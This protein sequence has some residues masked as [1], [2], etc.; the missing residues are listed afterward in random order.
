M[1]AHSNKR[2]HKASSKTAT[3]TATAAAT[4]T[5]HTTPTSTSAAANKNKP[6]VKGLTS[7]GV[8]CKEA[9]A[10]AGGVKAKGKGNVS[11]GR[12]GGDGGS[13]DN[14]NGNGLFKTTAAAK[15]S[16]TKQ[17]HLKRHL[18]PYAMQSPL[19]NTTTTTSTTAASKHNASTSGVRIGTASS[20]VSASGDGALGASLGGGSEKRVRFSEKEEVYLINK[21]V[22]SSQGQGLVE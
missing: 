1:S 16:P 13:H 22:S 18:S 7:A 19:F 4:N 2:S 17:R 14:D 12:N 15:L 11:G 9:A 20:G 21:D 3:A 8:P 5:P 10:S 6:H